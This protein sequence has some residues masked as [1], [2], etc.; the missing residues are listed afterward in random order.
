MSTTTA[1]EVIRANVQLH[2]AE[3]PYYERIHEEIFNP[4]ESV[5]IDHRLKRAVKALGGVRG[6]AL[7]F[8]AGTGN[9]ARRL[10]RM[11]F[12][13]VAFELSRE[14]ILQLK[15]K[16]EGGKIHAVLG[17]RLPFRRGS[18]SLVCA[19]SVLHHVPDYVAVVAELA[20]LLEPGGVLYLDH[21][22]DPQSPMLLPRREYDVYS[23]SASVLA[24]I[25]RRLTGFRAPHLDYSIAD[26]HTKQEDHVEWARI[27]SRLRDLGIVVLEERPYLM[28]PSWI[29][30]P[31]FPLLSFWLADLRYMIAAR[32]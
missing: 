30:N 27:R 7:D 29:P 32:L 3:A 21:E 2:R 4:I 26:F 9:I 15:G 19:F 16:K 23:V 1:G 24:E 14:M 28:H 22:V 12:G 6:R 20:S 25:R 31:L 17:E 5:R 11:G 8:G 10:S 18:F 13:V